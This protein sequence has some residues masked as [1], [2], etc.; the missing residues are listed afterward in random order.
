M[1]A[2]DTHASWCCRCY[3]L[4]CTHS[5]GTL[6]PPPSTP[7]RTHSQ[8]PPRRSRP[9]PPPRCCLRPPSPQ[10]RRLGRHPRPCRARTPSWRLRRPRRPPARPRLWGQMIQVRRV[11]VGQ[12]G[13]CA[14]H[15]CGAHARGGPPPAPPARTFAAA[16]LAAVLGPL[17]AALL[18]HRALGSKLLVPHRGLLLLRHRGALRGRRHAEWRAEH[19]ARQALT[20]CAAHDGLASSTTNTCARARKP[21]ALL[22]PLPLVRRL[23]PAAAAAIAPNNHAGSRAKACAV[24]IIIQ[25]SRRGERPARQ[26]FQMNTFRTIQNSPTNRRSTEKDCSFKCLLDPPPRHHRHQFT[27]KKHT[28]CTRSVS[29]AANT[30]AMFSQGTVFN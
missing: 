8:A 29:H 24:R 18:A 6:A 13:A 25:A 15:A 9:P 1:D 16:A 3:S 26:V 2:V 11:V 23:A 20:P 28:R 30:S 4:C 22:H 10:T 14:G 7:A 17:A 27:R 12:A 21:A 5:C 19:T